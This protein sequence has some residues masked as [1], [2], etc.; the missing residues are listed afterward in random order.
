MRGW[1]LSG[2][3]LFDRHSVVD[4]GAGQLVDITPLGDT[5][6]YSLFLPHDG[7]QSEFDKLPN[8]VVTVDF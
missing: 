4:L 2:S 7:S 3:T 6:P 8:Q 1:I 5:R